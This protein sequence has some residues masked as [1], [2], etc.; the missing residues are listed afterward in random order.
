MARKHARPL[1]A[2]GDAF[3]MPLAD[4]R[5]GVCRVLRAG[6]T[7]DPQALGAG[8]VLVGATAWIGTAPPDPADPQLRSLLVL[9]H[10]RWDRHLQI[11][12]VG[13]PPP[14]TFRRLGVIAPSREEQRLESN[15]FGGWE[16][17][18]LQVLLQWRW[19]HDRKALLAEEEK[20]RQQE[21][22]AR[23]EAASRPDPR[24]LALSWESLRQEKMFAGW[25]GYVEPEKLRGSRKIMRQ[26]IDA[27]E[28]LG[29]EPPEWAVLDVLR[30]CVE[31]FNELDEETDGF[32]YT[33]EREDICER[34]YDLI[35]LTGLEGLDEVADRWRDW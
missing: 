27:L 3:V 18:A 33:I 5:F 2:P 35:Q 25:Q 12:W 21:E 23:Q 22:L 26:V 15:S 16:N 31:R 13:E 9:E 24:L 19:D 20:E 8:C 1:P 7:E 34:L 14:A 28:A 10:H 32:I 11:L 17:F 29:P 30:R 4:G 6:P